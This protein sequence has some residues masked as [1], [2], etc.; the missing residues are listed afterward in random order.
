MLFLNKSYEIKIWDGEY[1]SQAL[2]IDT[3]TDLVKAW[4]E[5]PDVATF[6]VASN[7]DVYY[8]RIEDIDKFFAKHPSSTLIF[9]NAPFDIDV[10]EKASNFNFHSHIERDLV[11]DVQVLY[12]LL[13]LATIGFVP[14]KYNLALLVKEYFNVE[15]TK[16]DEVR[17]E[18]GQ[19]KGLPVEEIPQ[20]FLEYGAKD[21]IATLALYNTLM[22]LI[23][24][25]GTTTTLSS[26][27]QVAGS[28]ALN[29]MYKRGIGYNINKGTELLASL[30]TQK[31]Y[32]QD[33]L[34]TYGWVRGIKG[35]SQSYD[36]ITKFL[37]LSLPRNTDGS[38][39]SK[40]EDLEKYRGNAFV[41][42]YLKY[43]EVEKA[44]TF[45]RKL[46]SD[47]I[48]PNYNAILKT[49][50]TSCSGPNF[51]QL[52]RVGG[53][54]ECFEAKEGHTF[55]ITDYSTVELATLAQVTYDMY[56]ESMMR[57]QINDGV[58]LHRYYASILYSKPEKDI[59]KEERQSAKAANFGFPG[60]LGVET[61]MTF[62]KGYGLKIDELEAKEMK[63]AWFQA[64]PEMEAYMKEEK[65]HVWTR[66]GRKRAGTT[67]CAEKNTPFQGLAADGAKI[68][69]YYLDQAGYQT[70]GFVQDEI[71]SEVKVEESE[72]L[73]V[74]HERIMIE[75][76]EQVVPDVKITVESMISSVYTK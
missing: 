4:T 21:A 11:M 12:R 74:N 18:F 69:L 24:A 54:R 33:I 37:G 35:V 17:C 2:A 25:T 46:D 36:R 76:M 15:L 52:P 49:G 39:S 75:A 44:S 67:Y 70:V 10:I 13:K 8:V 16:D 48:H 66:T 3:E 50:R 59:T 22:P 7:N 73:L 57:N 68:A 42:A 45:L 14:R 72:E 34:S 65:G 71:I 64:F 31:T 47:R 30:D 40:G 27:I 41:D 60:G 26:T 19:Y 61:F 55:L 6:Q 28:L 58:D 56:G 63:K 20:D 9:A 62:A 23:A 5:T 38:V 29:R 32:Q 43:I 51:Q 1:L 53:I